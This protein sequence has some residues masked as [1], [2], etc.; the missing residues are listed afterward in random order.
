MGADRQSDIRRVDSGGSVSNGNR[1]ADLQRD[2][3]AR[4]GAVA[5]SLRARSRG[6]LSRARCEPLA[7][8]G[9]AAISA[10]I[11]ASAILIIFGVR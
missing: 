7:W 6:I 4:R 10:G 3:L 5:V 2:Y 11:A 1:L 9:V 8:A